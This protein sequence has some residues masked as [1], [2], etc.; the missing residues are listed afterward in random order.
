M[1]NCTTKYV[2]RFQ[3][4]E[5]DV[6]MMLFMDMKVLESVLGAHVNK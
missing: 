1:S 6:P 3:A 5:L 2:K 4:N